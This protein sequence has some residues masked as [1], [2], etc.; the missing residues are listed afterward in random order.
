MTERAGVL[1][2]DAGLAAAAEELDAAASTPAPHPD[3]EAWE[4]TNALTVG[5]AL[6]H[7][8][9]T[10]RET[11]GSHWREDFPERDDDHWL[12]HVDL[13]MTDGSTRSTYHPA[14]TVPTTGVTA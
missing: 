6:V 5:A 1:R 14:T 9:R 11:R 3:T 13:T 12:G 7:A 10:R 8:A 2:S 4:A